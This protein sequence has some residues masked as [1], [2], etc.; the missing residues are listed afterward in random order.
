LPELRVYGAQW[1]TKIDGE[2][3]YPKEILQEAMTKLAQGD[4]TYE[5]ASVISM[6]AY[7]FSITLSLEDHNVWRKVIVPADITF[8][9][10]HF[11]IQAAFRWQGYHLYEFMIFNNDE[12][13]A[14]IAC[15]EEAL[16]DADD[17]G[18][19]IEMDKKT[20][21]IKY[22][23]QFNRIKYVYDFGD[24][25]TH[26]IELERVIDDYPQN[27]PICVDGGGSCPPEDVG[28]EPGYENFLEVLNN[29]NHPEHEEMVS[30]G[31][32]QGY[33]EFNI[34]NV[35]FYLKRSLLQRR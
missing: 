10:F 5:V 27:Y 31:N 4:G 24:D 12:P 26:Y 6:K 30:W 23:P 19:P 16:E 8:R 35:N 25:W 9:K 34:E 20:K 14:L 32:M 17:I 11:V 18:Y 15:D 29:P 7:Q 3:K 2:Y 13:I 33:G 21:L 1:L 22:L 28:G